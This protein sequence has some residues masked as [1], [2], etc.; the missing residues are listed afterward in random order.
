MRPIHSS[1]SFTHFTSFTS[2]RSIPT[3]LDVLCLQGR[4]DITDPRIDWNILNRDVSN[5][6]T[7]RAHIE[8]LLKFIF[9]QKNTFSNLIHILIQTKNILCIE[10][11]LKH[12]GGPTGPCRPWQHTKASWRPTLYAGFFLIWN[13]NHLQ[14]IKKKWPE[15]LRR[16]APTK[17]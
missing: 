2:H 1:S 8:W 16:Y 15:E 6:V 14:R 9:F 12:I 3:S 17:V 10:W 4:G 7:G 5:W 11:L 13:T